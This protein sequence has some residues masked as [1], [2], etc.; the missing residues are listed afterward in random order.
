MKINKYF[1]ILVFLFC[2]SV[3]S[4]VKDLYLSREVSRRFKETESFELAKAVMYQNDT[5]IR[6]ICAQNPEIMY[7][8]DNEFH[9][10]LLHFAISL[11]K[12]KSAKALLDSGMS[13]NV[14]SSTTGET[15]LY[16][17]TKY[18]NIDIKF[19][20]LLIDYGADPEIGTKS[21]K[22]HIFVAGS[23]PLMELPTMH[24]PSQKS[25][26]EKAKYLIEIGKANIN[27]TDIDGRTAA[28]QALH[29]QDVE[30]TYYF[31]VELKADITQPY[32]SPDYVVLE[33]E[34]K[35][36]HYPVSLLRDFWI[37]PLDSDEY[38]MKR[39]IIEEFERQS[40]DYRNTLPS[41]YALQKIKQLYPNTW[42]EYLQKY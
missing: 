24:I 12:Y 28:I 2:L 37:Y 10:T 7:V 5:K 20:K 39:K 29:I 8:E 16:I 31:I 26:M 1:F 36:K 32:Y 19:L 18:S 35:K 27:K 17:A 25:N 4:F 33:G 13:A 34:E 23:T 14:Q 30:M 38:K 6:K 40:V 15:P 41:K 22:D 9:Y 42:E 21:L 11:K 3:C